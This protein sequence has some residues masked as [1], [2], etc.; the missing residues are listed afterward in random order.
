MPSCD[1]HSQRFR[2]GVLLFFFL[3]VTIALG[4]ADA[5]MLRGVRAM[6]AVAA[7]SCVGAYG[8]WTVFGVALNIIRW[9][10]RKRGD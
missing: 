2:L 7:G 8:A 5:M 4:V 10:R 9:A 1:P 3:G 6:A